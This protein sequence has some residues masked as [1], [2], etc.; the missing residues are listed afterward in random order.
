MLYNND[1]LSDVYRN[2]EIHTPVRSVLL[3]TFFRV[4]YDK[5]PVERLKFK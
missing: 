2:L 5:R 3:F 4:F 1:R